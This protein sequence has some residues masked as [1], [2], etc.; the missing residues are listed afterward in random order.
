MKSDEIAGTVIGIIFGIIII[1]LVYYIYNKF[2]IEQGYRSLF[3]DTH[4]R[5]QYAKK[6]PTEILFAKKGNKL[7]VDVR[8]VS[9]PIIDQS[10]SIEINDNNNNNSN[11]NHKNSIDMLV[12]K[13]DYDHIQ[14]IDIKKSLSIVKAGY[15]HKKSTSVMKDWLKRWFFIID[16]KLFYSNQSFNIQ[17]DN[18]TFHEEIH[19]YQVANLLIST[20]KQVTS[21]EFQII[22]P[23]QRG[24]GK[25]GGVYELLGDNEEDVSDWIRV[26]KLQIEG[27]LVDSSIN[28]NISN[29]SIKYITID[30]KILNELYNY[31]PTCADCNSPSPTWASLN[32]CIMICIE[33]S[34][35]HRS[36]GS[37]ISKVRSL[38]LDKWTENY[39][40]L[41]ITIGNK[42][43]NSIWDNESASSIPI[44]A[45]REI[46]ESY[47]T[48]KY[49][50]KLYI[51]KNLI[52]IDSNNLLLRAAGSGKAINIIRGIASNGNVNTT[53]MNNN[54]DTGK[55]PLHFAVE[56]NHILCIELL[57]LFNANINQIDMDHKSP[58]DIALQQNRPEIIDIFNNYIK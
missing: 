17:N 46:R 53:W 38:T 14:T 30:Q 24:T 49:I 40:Q 55:T 41:L 11:K 31:N 27:S 37:H 22:S 58:F 3:D 1:L 2:I 16:G 20:V 12:E 47:I 33:C 19:A 54:I 8:E 26:I 45:P 50:N 42:K 25:G 23:G 35:I 18:D 43:S 34:G 13:E 57:C 28:N 56:G 36:L 9:N 29:N 39:I 6:K 4:E 5:A 7:N 21:K 15:L 10:Y 32:L 52:N 44:N 48:N 51:N